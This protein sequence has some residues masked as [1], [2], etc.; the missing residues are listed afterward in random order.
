MCAR[1]NDSKVEIGSEKRYLFLSS[2]TDFDGLH[3]GGKLSN[4]SMNKGVP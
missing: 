3:R 2:V 1:T 4:A